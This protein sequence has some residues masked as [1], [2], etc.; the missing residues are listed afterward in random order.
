MQY[1]Q[2]FG[3]LSTWEGVGEYEIQ[4]NELSDHWQQLKLSV[5]NKLC[6]GFGNSGQLELIESIAGKIIV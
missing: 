5:E 6:E 1:Y 4:Q 2:I 3:F